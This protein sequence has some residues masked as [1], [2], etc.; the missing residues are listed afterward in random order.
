MK[1][2]EMEI[3]QYI[4]GELSSD[5]TKEMF[6][7]IGECDECRG[8]LSDFI[9]LKDKARLYCAENIKEISNTPSVKRSGFYKY[10]FYASS[11]A[12]LIL[13]FLLS[14]F[15]QEQKPEI[16]NVTRIDTVYVEKEVRV[17]A[18]KEPRQSNLVSNKSRNAG[19]KSPY[20]AFIMSLKTESVTPA[21]KITSN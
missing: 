8:L 16:L 11:A 2:Y 10:A 7:H 5:E 12:A 17:P 4:D 20:M 9:V 21:D 14:T 1:H 3:N 19:N 18:L 15:K 6:R 13:L